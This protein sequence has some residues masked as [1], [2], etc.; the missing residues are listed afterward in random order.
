MPQDARVLADLSFPL[1]LDGELLLV[2]KQQTF[3]GFETIINLINS[4]S[5]Y[6]PG[7]KLPTTI[8][9]CK[10]KRKGHDDPTLEYSVSDRIVV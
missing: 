5:N 3:L 10:G 2:Q 7:K 6:A 8:T 9:Q 4:S 1:K